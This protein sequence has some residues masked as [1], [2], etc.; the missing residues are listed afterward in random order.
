MFLGRR[1]LAHGSRHSPSR[2]RETLNKCL[3]QPHAR[4]ASREKPSQNT[5][6]EDNDAGSSTA[7]KKE[8]NPL[9]GQVCLLTTG[10]LI[11]VMHA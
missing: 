6:P 5:L 1:E 10:V 2:W 3:V 8:K 4:C 11:S 9:L 7:E